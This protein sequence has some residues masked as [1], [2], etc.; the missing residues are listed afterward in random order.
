M[1]AKVAEPLAIQ[2]KAYGTAAITASDAE[3]AATTRLTNAGRF[4]KRQ[5]CTEQR[6]ATDHTDALRV[7]VRAAWGPEQP[8]TTEMFPA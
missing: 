7:Q 5:T 8:H 3:T 4:G 1:R 6:T 2:T